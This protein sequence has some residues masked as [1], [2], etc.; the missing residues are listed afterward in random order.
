MQ[1]AL[2][3]L[4]AGRTTLVIAHRLSTVRNAHRIVALEDGRIVETGTH[5]SL[6]AQNGLYRRLYE[7]QFAQEEEKEQPA[8]APMAA[9]ASRRNDNSSIKNRRG[10]PLGRPTLPPADMHPYFHHLF[11]CLQ[12]RGEAAAAPRCSLSRG[13]RGPGRGLWPGGAA[14]AQS[15]CQ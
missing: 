1:Q 3:S 13:G 9:G 11:D 14:A 15:L 5:T 4:I 10:D 7:M 2:D 6:L 12:G 8:S